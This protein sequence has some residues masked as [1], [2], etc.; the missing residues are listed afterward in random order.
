MPQVLRYG[1]TA[2]LGQNKVP[3][4]LTQFQ[5]CKLEI[6][7]AFGA[8]VEVWVRRMLLLKLERD[9]QAA[10]GGRGAVGWW[11]SVTLWLTDS[12][13]HM[14][15][16]ALFA[17]FLKAIRAA[18]LLSY[19]KVPESECRWYEKHCQCLSWKI[20]ILLVC[21]GLGGMDSSGVRGKGSFI[22]GKQKI[23]RVFTA[24]SLKIINS[25]QFQFS[26]EL[27]SN[28]K[29]EKLF[30]KKQHILIHMGKNSIV[31][32]ISRKTKNSI[33]NM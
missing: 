10:D 19:C 5:H 32:T 20:N 16:Q 4:I 30:L 2:S 7:N 26:P 3:D 24:S 1:N 28:K 12:S 17:Q 22:M 6:I 13:P 11:G 31:H 9:V 27:V 15:C 33:K 21:S 29:I 8:T 23:L 14:A 25:F 18:P